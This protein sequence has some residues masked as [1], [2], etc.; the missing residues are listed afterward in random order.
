MH[1]EPE[2]LSVVGIAAF[3][4]AAGLVT[5]RPVSIPTESAH[6]ALPFP[7]STDLH[8]AGQL[9]GLQLA[10]RLKNI[11]LNCLHSTAGAAQH[12]QPP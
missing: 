10:A 2:K 1:N 6:Q 7:L 12:R 9:P 11:S 5:F 4:A 8:R 3:S